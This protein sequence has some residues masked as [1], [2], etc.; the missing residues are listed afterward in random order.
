MA[1]RMQ[2]V[3]NSV[4]LIGTGKEVKKSVMLVDTRKRKSMKEV[5]C[6]YG[7]CKRE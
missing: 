7:R 2:E 3:N 6:W 5:E 1:M 4:M